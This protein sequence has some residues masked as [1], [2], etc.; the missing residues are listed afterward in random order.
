MRVLFCKITAMKYYKGPSLDDPPLN[1]GSW[2]QENDM[3]HEAWN[4][5]PVEKDGKSYCFGFVEPKSNRGNRN[6]IH[7]E[8][9]SGT[10]SDKNTDCIENVI[11]IWCATTD[12]NVTAVVGWY[13][14]A[15]VYRQIQDIDREDMESG[16]NI[17]DES[18]NCILLPRNE[19]DKH[20]WTAPVSRSVGYGF[21]SAM[22][23]YPSL[24]ESEPMVKKILKEIDEYH[25]SNWINVFNKW[26]ESQY[27]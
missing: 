17:V 22:T 9:I 15:T 20:K 6:T 21:G 19:R 8:N 1:G 27:K 7:I 14:N 24:D 26:Q 12:R 3:G 4:F 23:W 11:V 25:G 10:P 2:V 13:K 16:Y 5:L 18:K